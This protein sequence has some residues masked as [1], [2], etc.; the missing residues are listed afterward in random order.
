[1][2]KGMKRITLHIEEAMYNDLQ[3]Y[4]EHGFRQHVVKSVLRA[5]IGAIK[6]R[7]PIVIGALMAD[8]YKL[9]LDES[10]KSGE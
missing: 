1:M 6:E 4:I 8:Q 3:V 9:V 5:V 2:S 10:I 7:G